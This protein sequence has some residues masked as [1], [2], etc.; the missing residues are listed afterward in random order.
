MEAHRIWSKSQRPHALGGSYGSI[1]VSWTLRQRSAM[2]PTAGISALLHQSLSLFS[3]DA[4]SVD[5]ISTT[6][7]VVQY[8]FSYQ[9]TCTASSRPVT[10]CQLCSWHYA[11]VFQ[12]LGKDKPPVRD[13]THSIIGSHKFCSANLKVTVKVFFKSCPKF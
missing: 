7:T 6:Q 8:Y 12:A 11:T 13:S 9:A 10:G 4:R 5:S 3:S 2:G 1:H